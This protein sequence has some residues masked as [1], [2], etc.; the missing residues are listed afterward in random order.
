MLTDGGLFHCNRARKVFI[1]EV[2][3]DAEIAADG[4]GGLWCV[5]NGYLY[6]VRE[7]ILKQ[8]FPL[9]KHADIESD[10]VGGVWALFD[11]WVWHCSEIDG[12]TKEKLE[13]RMDMS[14]EE[15]RQKERLKKKY[16]FPNSTRILGCV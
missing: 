16:E 5:F 11:G 10:G 15:L 4:V 9:P 8:K 2:P 12:F 13:S 6:Q 14:I 3:E 1:S 7:G